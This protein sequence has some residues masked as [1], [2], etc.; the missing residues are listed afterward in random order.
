MKKIGLLL[1]AII[2][3]LCGCHRKSDV[4]KIGVIAPLTG[5]ASIILK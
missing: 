3:I 1:T 5:A 2:L 4:V